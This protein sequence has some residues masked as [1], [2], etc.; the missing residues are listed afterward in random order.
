MKP[1]IGN[2]YRLPEG[3]S[4]VIVTG[5]RTLKLSKGSYEVVDWVSFDMQQSSGTTRLKHYPEMV[6]CGCTY[7]DTTGDCDLNP[8]PA[9]E[10]CMGTGFE[11]I[12]IKGF[13]KATF[14]AYHC[15]DYI[16]KALTKPFNF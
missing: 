12:E 1:R 4:I 13:E 10:Q 5:I 3:G 15:K 8:D 14:L 11:E 16:M 9:C 7:N 6:E 2:V